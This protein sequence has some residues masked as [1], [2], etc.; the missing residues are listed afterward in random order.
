[1]PLKLVAAADRQLTQVKMVIYGKPGLGKT[2]LALSANKPVLLEFDDEGSLR[3]GIASDN[4]VP[5]S[6]WDDV[7]SITPQDLH[8]FDTVVVDTVGAALGFLKDAVIKNDRKMGYNGE[9]TQAGWGRLAAQFR[10]FMAM[11]GRSGRNIILIAHSKEVST[12]DGITERLD[13]QGSTV[14]LV[15]QLATAMGCLDLTDHG[16]AIR[17]APSQAAFGKDPA[18]LGMVAVPPISNDVNEQFLG[19]LITDIK[20]TV[21][22][23][24]NSRISQATEAEPQPEAEPVLDAASL[25]FTEDEDDDLP[26]PDP[27]PAV[28]YPEDPFGGELPTGIDVNNLDRVEYAWYEGHKSVHDTKLYA[29]AFLAGKVGEYSLYSSLVERVQAGAR[30]ELNKEERTALRHDI[31]GA[32]LVW[33]NA[34]GWLEKQQ[35][36]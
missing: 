34:K 3:A 22:D 7:G 33:N 8:P 28:I 27:K 32:G 6:S 11:L 23:R 20:R 13:I 24:R 10:Q 29:G 9:L 30:G 17:F 15:Y 18:G 31:F 19:D 25:P 35:A 26:E 1:M 2:T 12:D 4:V 36:N 5:V 21:N 14:Q 16:R